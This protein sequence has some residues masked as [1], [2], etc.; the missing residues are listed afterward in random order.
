MLAEPT[1]SGNRSGDVNSSS[2]VVGDVVMSGR[3]GGVQPAESLQGT[4]IGATTTDTANPPAATTSLLVDPAH[5]TRRRTNSIVKR[6]RHLDSPE[7]SPVPST[8]ASTA[9][10]TSTSPKSHSTASPSRRL[11]FTSSSS[12]SIPSVHTLPVPSTSGAISSTLVIP[13][14]RGLNLAKS[15]ASSEPYVLSAAD[16]RKHPRELVPLDIGFPTPDFAGRI[17]KEDSDDRLLMATCAVL[18][19]HGNRALCPKEMAEVMFEK[20]WLHN[21]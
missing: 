2:V 20:K 11:S 15:V 3:E 12:P 16:K 6:P 14:S 19:M 4:T 21:A 9:F 8:S 1:R 5:Q 10:A 7:P 18:Y 17:R 13:P